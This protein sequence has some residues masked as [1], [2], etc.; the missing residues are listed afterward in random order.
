MREAGTTALTIPLSLYVH[1]PWCVRKCPYCDFNSHPLS[2]TLDEMGYLRA[3][4][5]DLTIQLADVH[6]ASIKTVF[7]GGGTPSLFSPAAFAELL[8]DLS[9]VISPDAEV[10]M[11]AN[12]GTTEYHKFE[13]Y[14]S[15]GINRL[16]LGAQSF[17]NIQLERL[18]RIHAASETIE[19]FAKARAGGFDNINLDL[20]Y[21]L[22]QQT[23]DDAMFDLSSAIALSPEHISWYQ[24]TI[25]PKTE[26]ARRPPILASESTVEDM[27]REGHALLAH[28]GY[29]RYE[30]SAYARDSHQCLHNL[31]YWTFG[32]YLGAGAGAHGKRSRATNIVRTSKPR[33]PR[34]YLADPL[35][36]KH[37]RLQECEVAAEFMMNALRLSAGVSFELFTER[38][39]LPFEV[40]AKRW[41]ALVDQG[42]VR[43][44]R[45]AATPLGYRHLDSLVQY[46]L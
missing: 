15:A 5:R 7:F 9:S 39:G 40:I 29:Q 41:R 21:A 19:S 22:S 28:A 25:E 10:T 6:A 3:L 11:E 33:Q 23:V 26:F 37:H 14:R 16:S 38:S 24:L 20:M 45:L 46:F 42:L 2:G 27:E 44:E 35:A 13:E 4:R 30:V 1:F 8:E 31:N 17:S 18:G 36:T 32:D 34:L 43:E 12:P